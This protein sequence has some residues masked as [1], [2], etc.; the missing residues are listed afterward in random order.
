MLNVEVNA[1]FQ[2]HSTFSIHFNIQTSAFTSAFSIQ[3]F[4]IVQSRLID[5]AAALLWAHW[6]SGARIPELPAPAPAG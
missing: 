1:E 4:S 6:S 2:H 3:H 5:D